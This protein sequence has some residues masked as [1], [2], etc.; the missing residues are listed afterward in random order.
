MEIA[1]RLLSNSGEDPD[2]AG[3]SVRGTAGELVLFIYDRIPAECLQIDGD[4]GLIDLLRA[5]DPEEQT[6][7][8]MRRS[9]HAP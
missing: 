2:A 7:L 5:C 9:R 6:S 1:V 4:A 8:T 3:V